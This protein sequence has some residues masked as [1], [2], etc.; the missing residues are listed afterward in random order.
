MNRILLGWIVNV[1]VWER[2]KWQYM[3][4]L[5]YFWKAES[6]DLNSLNSL[7]VFS[8]EPQMLNRLTGATSCRRG[9]RMMWTLG[10]G[11]AVK[12][13]VGRKSWTIL[14]LPKVFFFFFNWQWPFCAWFVCCYTFVAFLPVSLMKREV[15]YGPL[16]DLKAKL[17]LIAP[18]WSLVL[19]LCI[20]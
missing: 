1:T 8:S 9:R 15:H 2:A 13:A 6:H 16:L 19:D 11:C 4:D 5:I 12:G 20:L 3:H 18:L 14:L 17:L 7:K 10:C